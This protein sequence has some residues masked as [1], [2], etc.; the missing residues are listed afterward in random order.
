MTEVR[1][2]DTPM[3]VLEQIETKP[4]LEIIAPS[5]DFKPLST[6]GLNDGALGVFTPGDLEDLRWYRK[7]GTLGTYIMHSMP[8]HIALREAR[9][10][11]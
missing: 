1:G 7:I 4:L 10:L 5:I 8:R 3:I 6:E 9:P 2:R 11:A